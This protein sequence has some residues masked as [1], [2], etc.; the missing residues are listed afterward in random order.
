MDAGRSDWRSPALTCRLVQGQRSPNLRPHAP[1]IFALTARAGRGTRRRADAGASVRFPSFHSSH[2][3]PIDATWGRI[4]ASC[5]RACED[6]AEIRH[7]LVPEVGCF[8]L[9]PS[10]V[11]DIGYT[12]C[13]LKAGT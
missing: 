2:P 8:R 4:R 3:P 13:L 11:A 5:A 10:K 9:R 12:R 1:A 6:T 7:P